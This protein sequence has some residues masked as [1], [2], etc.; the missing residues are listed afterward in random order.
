[1]PQALPDHLAGANLGLASGIGPGV[2]IGI[3][4]R[5]IFLQTEHGN[6]LWDLVPFIDD[7]FVEEVQEKGGLKAIVVC[8]ALPYE[9]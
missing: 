3:G 9:L 5:A 7:K 1:V 2:K 4:Q 8:Y 6:V